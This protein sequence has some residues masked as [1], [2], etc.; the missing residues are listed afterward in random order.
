MQ[1][2][3]AGTIRLSSPPADLRRAAG[4]DW[5]AG[6]CGAPPLSPTLEVIPRGKASGISRT[7]HPH[8]PSVRYLLAAGARPQPADRWGG[9]PLTDAEG[10]GHTHVAELIRQAAQPAERKVAI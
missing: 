7:L 8:L 1:N 5:S 6:R 10:N 4:P 9:T 2:P 3:S